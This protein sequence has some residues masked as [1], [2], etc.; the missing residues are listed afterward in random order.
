[1]SDHG[2]IKRRLEPVEIAVV[3]QPIFEV[4]GDDVRLYGAKGLSRRIAVCSEVC[5]HD[6]PS[7]S[8]GPTVES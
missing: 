5:V 2:L 3:F 6:G 1:M 7:V 8:Q 4:Q